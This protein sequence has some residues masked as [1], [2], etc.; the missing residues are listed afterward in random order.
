MAL[1]LMLVTSCQ[2]NSGPGNVI[3]TTSTEP[4]APTETRTSPAPASDPLPPL[5]QHVSLRDPPDVP[6]APLLVLVERN[7]WLMVVGSDAPT[8]AVYADGTLIRTVPVVDGPPFLEAGQLSDE[9]LDTYRAVAASEALWGLASWHECSDWTDQPTNELV[10]WRGAER[11]RIAVYGSLRPPA[12]D[13]DEETRT[14]VDSERARTPAPFLAAFDALVSLRTS[15]A[16]E[17]LP[18]QLEVLVWPYDNSQMVPVPWPGGWPGLDTSVPANGADLRAIMIPSTEL[19]RLRGLLATLG[20]RQG[21]RLAERT[22]TLAWRVPFP[23][24]RAWMH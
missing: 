10:L 9:D 3:P 15:G 22:W 14:T 1:L 2:R 21:V 5:P 11:H 24:E 20:G 12:S 4:E 6:G 13:A 19:P 8:L 7:P 16:T 23:G 17:W 18:R